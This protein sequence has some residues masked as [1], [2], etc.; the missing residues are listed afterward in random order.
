MDWS[1]LPDSAQRL[2]SG[3]LTDVETLHARALAG[4]AEAIHRLAAALLAQR[5]KTAAHLFGEEATEQARR[6]MG[7]FTQTED[8]RRRTWEQ[9]RDLFPALHAAADALPPARRGVVTVAAQL[10]KQL[11]QDDPLRK[12]ATEARIKR[13][14]RLGRPEHP[15]PFQERYPY[16]LPIDGE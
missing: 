7:T 2:P 5:L 12:L 3:D 6:R 13:W 8:R 15:A 11:G 10:R 4:D 14:I 9:D 16:P 1:F